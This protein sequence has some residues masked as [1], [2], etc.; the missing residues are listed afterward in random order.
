VALSL[1]T[2]LGTVFLTLPVSR[3]GKK[4]HLAVKTLMGNGTFHPAIILTALKLVTRNPPKEQP[5]GEEDGVFDPRE[6]K[7][8][9]PKKIKRPTA[10]SSRH[11]SY[12]SGLALGFPGAPWKIRAT[13]VLEGEKRRS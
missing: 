5:T 3:V 8:I 10:C 6:I 12:T 13:P 2:L 7:K 11:S 1:A 4:E 9:N